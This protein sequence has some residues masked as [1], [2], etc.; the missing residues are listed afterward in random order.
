MKGGSTA[1]LMGEGDLLLNTVLK[2]V[3][4]TYLSCPRL[5]GGGM[6]RPIYLTELKSTGTD[7]EFNYIGEKCTLI[8][9]EFTPKQ[10]GFP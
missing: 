8:H 9:H 7:K 10:L 2:H 4:Q 3:F 5:E 1:V 6:G